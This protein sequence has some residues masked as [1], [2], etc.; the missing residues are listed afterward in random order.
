M[1][2][3]ATSRDVVSKPDKHEFCDGD[4][5]DCWIKVHTA[6]GD[7]ERYFWPFTQE[8]LIIAA[9]GQHPGGRTWWI[10]PSPAVLVIEH[11]EEMVR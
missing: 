2:M 11:I 3:T 4:F 9:P 1:T 8:Q 10:M 5:G 6:P 7:F